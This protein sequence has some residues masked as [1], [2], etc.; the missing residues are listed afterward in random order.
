M[1]VEMAT[2][3]IRE[4]GDERRMLIYGYTRQCTQGCKFRPVMKPK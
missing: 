4:D 1:L 3:R 2:R